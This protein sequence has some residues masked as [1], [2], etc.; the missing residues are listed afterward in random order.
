MKDFKS[1]ISI[2]RSIRSGQACIKDTRITI[3]DILSYLKFGMSHAEILNDFPELSN[4]D[5]LVALAYAESQK[6]TL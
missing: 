1:N 4:D 5:I 6:R 3:A 2:N